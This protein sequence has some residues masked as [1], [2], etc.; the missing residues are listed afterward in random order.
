MDRNIEGLQF[1]FGNNMDF[2]GHNQKMDARK[3]NNERRVNS[4]DPRMPHQKMKI[5][6]NGIYKNRP[7]YNGRDD[8]ETSLS[9]PHSSIPINLNLGNV[10]H[11]QLMNMQRRVHPAYYG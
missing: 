10:Q 8:Q 4:Q 5:D 2:N 1:N 6:M 7:A 3:N 9:N 11:K